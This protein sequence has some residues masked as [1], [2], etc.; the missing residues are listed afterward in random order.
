MS[1][2]AF[3]LFGRLLCQNSLEIKDHINF[4]RCCWGLQT[5]MLLSF[6]D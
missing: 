3:F 2:I 5:V 4:W 1:E 6:K